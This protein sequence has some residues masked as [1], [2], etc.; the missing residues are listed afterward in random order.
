[1]SQTR[2][3]ADYDGSNPRCFPRVDDIIIRFASLPNSA[4]ALPL[5]PAS[6]CRPRPSRRASSKAGMATLS[7]HGSDPGGTSRSDRINC[8]RRAVLRLSKTYRA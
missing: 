5:H 7:I 3:L 1:M 8:I 2:R 4:A 6:P